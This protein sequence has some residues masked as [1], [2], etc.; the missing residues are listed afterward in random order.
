MSQRLRDNYAH[1]LNYNVNL[2]QNRVKKEL[3]QT[4]SPRRRKRRRGTEIRQQKHLY[5]TKAHEVFIRLVKLRNTELI[6]TE[7]FY[8]WFSTPESKLI[9]F[10]DHSD[11]IY[12]VFFASKRSLLHKNI[13]MQSRAFYSTLL[14]LNEK[15]KNF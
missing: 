11:G 5:N 12:S 4:E 6:L 2:P 10:P 9:K 14:R 8:T 13:Q 15:N 1:R 3:F 7:S